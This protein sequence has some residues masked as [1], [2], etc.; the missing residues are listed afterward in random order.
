MIDR[1]HESTLL[2]LAARDPEVKYTDAAYA[3]AAALLELLCYVRTPQPITIQTRYDPAPTWPQFA[4]YALVHVDGP[5]TPIHPSI[6]P[7]RD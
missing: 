1:Q 7:P 4:P 3:I 2:R 6:D 5:V